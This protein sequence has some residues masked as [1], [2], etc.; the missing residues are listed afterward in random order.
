MIDVIITHLSY[1]VINLTLTAFIALNR[2]NETV[3]YLRAVN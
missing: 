1:C 2:I 3:L